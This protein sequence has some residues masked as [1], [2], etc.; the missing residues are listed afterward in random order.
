M[1]KNLK[2]KMQRSN[3]TVGFTLIEALVAIAVLMVAITGPMVLAQKSLSSADLS[4]DQTTASFLAQDAIEDVLNIRDTIA[5][6]QTTG[7]WL[8]G[9][10]SQGFL[11]PCI[12]IGAACNFDSK[13]PQ[14]C[15]ID[16]TFLS[17]WTAPL[18]IL[19]GNP[20]SSML[21][22]TYSIDSNG[23][24]HFLTY[25]YNPNNL[26][27]CSSNSTP[28]SKCSTVSKFSRYINIQIDPTNTNSNEAVIN[29][30]VSWNSPLG[31]Q[32]IPLQRFIYNYSENLQ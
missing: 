30:R 11:A 19:P 29:V 3:T 32:K 1:M 2:T 14:F 5:V 15:N 25:D 16:T 6:S 13:A 10:T 27:S 24:K 21:Y 20:N 9:P 7:S 26:S 31:V 28:G 12:C 17:H 18:A 23:A 8:T 22:M 4:K